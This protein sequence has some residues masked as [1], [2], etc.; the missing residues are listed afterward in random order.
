MVPCS[1]VWSIADM[2]TVSVRD[3]KRMLPG[4]VLSLKET[5]NGVERRYPRQPIFLCDGRPQK[6]NGG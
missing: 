2:L 6:Q 1:C 5:A 4:V 3:V